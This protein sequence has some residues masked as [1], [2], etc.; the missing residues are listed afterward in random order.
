MC[1][2]W[3]F[4]ESGL[5]DGESMGMEI[6]MTLSDAYHPF[7]SVLVCIEDLC[8]KLLVSGTAFCDLFKLVCDRSCSLSNSVIKDNVV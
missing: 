1:V 8:E 3:L 5:T 2:Y 7:L 6:I 4:S